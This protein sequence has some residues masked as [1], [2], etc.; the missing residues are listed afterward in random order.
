MDLAEIRNGETL[1]EMARLMKHV[2]FIVVSVKPGARLVLL[3]TTLTGPLV[4]FRMA[5][6]ETQSEACPAW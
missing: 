6:W 4:A 5:Q 2:F 1:F 3:T